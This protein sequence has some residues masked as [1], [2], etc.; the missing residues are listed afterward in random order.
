MGLQRLQFG[1]GLGSPVAVPSL[2]FRFMYL[3]NY[4]SQ[5]L[6][7]LLG[8]EG[9]RP[10]MQGKKNKSPHYSMEAWGAGEAFF[11]IQF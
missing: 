8:S 9:G 10:V 11:P 7:H 6:L 1:N 5:I 3:L 2:V 4:L